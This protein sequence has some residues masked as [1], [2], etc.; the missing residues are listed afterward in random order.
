MLAWVEKGNF[1]KYYLS[2]AAGGSG[3]H[4]GMYEPSKQDLQAIRDNILTNTAHGVALRN[5]VSDYS[6]LLIRGS[7]LKLAALLRQ[8]VDKD[9]CKEFGAPPKGAAKST[10]RTSLWGADDELKRSPKDYSPDHP[11]IDW[12]RL[13]HFT[14][15]H[16]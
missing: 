16:R 9:F 1:A 2:I 13:K 7:R 11:D 5:L 15:S 8:V 6:S 14:V 4:A 10:K 12:L 3:L